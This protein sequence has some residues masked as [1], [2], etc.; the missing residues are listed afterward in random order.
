LDKKIFVALSTFG[1]QGDIPLKIL[2]ESR[3]SYFINQLGRRLTQKEIIAM[4]AD[5]EGVIAGLEPYDDYVLDNMPNLRCISRC[6][7]GVDN[8]SLEKAKERGITI[9]NTPE[10]VIQPVAELTVAMIFDLLRRLSWQTALMK[11]GQWKKKTGSLLVGKK[12]GIL[13][14]GRIG[15]RVA[16]IMVKLDSEVYG[17]DI[18]PD[19]A[20]AEQTDIQIVS[21]DELL[22]ISDI[23][24]IHLSFMEGNPFQLG[25]KEIAMMKEGALVIN[26]ARGSFIDEEALYNALKKEYLAGA[27]LDVFSKE[28]YA[29]KLCELENVVLTPHIATLTKESRLQMEME[30]TQSIINFFKKL[31]N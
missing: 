2:S 20:W 13:G 9:F 8:I 27:A 3:L 11:S 23:L 1:Q 24:S 16:E 17:A 6:G 31:I 18:F 7:V 19:N 12:I 10:V 30:A 15:R 26:V 25:E 22:Q 28:P 21:C 14:L 29:G 5:C 4:G